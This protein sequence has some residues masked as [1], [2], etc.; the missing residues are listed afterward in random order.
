MN[1]SVPAALE[2]ERLDRVVAILG[3]LSRSRAAAMIDAGEVQ[4]NGQVT[5]DRR[6]RLAIGDTVD[7]AVA[8]DP[9]PD[10][11]EP[12]PDVSF[13]VRYE[14]DHLLVVDKPAGV[15]VHP[16]A[17]RDRGTLCH[18]LLAHYPELAQVGDPARPGIVHRLD[19]GTSG[20]LVVARSDETY[21]A[22]VALLSAHDVER[23]YQ[24]M[25]WGVL[26]GPDGLIDAPIGRSRRDPT[27]MTVTPRGKPARTHYRVEASLFEPA[28]TMLTC[29]LETGRTHQI[30]VHLSSI[31]HPVVADRVYRGAP[32]QGVRLDR[33]WLHARALR[34]VHPVTGQEV[35][36]VSPLPPDLAATWP[37]PRPDRSPDG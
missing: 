9:G 34:F 3:D 6:R 29:W 14:D 22:L 16:G 4:V 28:R 7:A 37:D 2:G 23:E 32:L 18:G 26:E 8:E 21:H 11:L 12:D 13:S 24:A 20:L 10:V 31:G 36:V 27:K 25:V 35:D 33:P 15:V 1:W 5:V 17:G 30:R 19:R